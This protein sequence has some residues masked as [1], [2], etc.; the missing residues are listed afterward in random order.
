MEM[1]EAS[2]FTAFKALWNEPCP[3]LSQDADD[4]NPS[5]GDIDLDNIP[6]CSQEAAMEILHQEHDGEMTDEECDKFLSDTFV[7]P[8]DP[9]DEEENMFEVVD[10][11][12]D[13]PHESKDFT[14]EA[15]NFI[16]NPKNSRSKKT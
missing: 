16:A 12:C 13:A 8:D 7:L 15:M 2:T 9:D 1:S 10:V 11:A 3:L 4:L 6:S 14:D 5:L